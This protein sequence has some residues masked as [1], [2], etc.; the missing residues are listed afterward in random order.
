MRHGCRA[1]RTLTGPNRTRGYH[2]LS[3]R[4]ACWWAILQAAPAIAR[5]VMNI[6]ILERTRILMATI[7]H[8]VTTLR[9]LNA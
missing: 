3:V 9:R 6:V 5:S 7:E 8:R 1:M 2:C 4:F